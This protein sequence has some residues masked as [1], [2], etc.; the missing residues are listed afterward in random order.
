M[1]AKRRLSLR[2]PPSARFRLSELSRFRFR[3]LLKKR[4]SGFV[5]GWIFGKVFFGRCFRHRGRGVGRGVGGS[6][7]SVFWGVFGLLKRSAG[8]ARSAQARSAQIRFLFFSLVCRQLRV[9]PPKSEVRRGAAFRGRKTNSRTNY[10]PPRCGPPSVRPEFGPRARILC[11]G[12]GV[13]LDDPP[14]GAARGAD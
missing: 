13:G 2:S 3:S 12:G 1:A 6:G 9:R 11:S 4:K 7:L 10:R 14:R 5:P 8:T